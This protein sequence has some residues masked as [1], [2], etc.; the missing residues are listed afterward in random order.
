MP[1]NPY[2]QEDPRR[3]DV[4]ENGQVAERFAIAPGM[5]KK[6]RLVGFLDFLGFLWGSFYVFLL[7]LFKGPFSEFLVSV[8]DTTRATGS[9]WAPK[10]L[11]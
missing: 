8:S 9:C 3:I 4:L 1:L 7:H 2:S 10:K 5:V 6:P 11:A